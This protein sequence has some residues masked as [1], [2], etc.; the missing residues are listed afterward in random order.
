MGRPNNKSE[1]QLAA[2]I[3]PE[4][5]EKVLIHGD[6]SALT[7]EERLHYYK[8]VCESLGLN[9]LFEPFDYIVLDR[10]LVLYAR[11][12]CTEQLRKI[13]GVSITDLSPPAKLEDV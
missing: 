9:P 2:T 10:M 7:P 8:S 5:I 11:K 12:D 3:S 13:H 1:T 6:L 4:T